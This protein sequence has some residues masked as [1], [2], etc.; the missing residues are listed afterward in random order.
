MPDKDYYTPTDER[1]ENVFAEYRK[2]ITALFVLAGKDQA[3]A[4]EIA[5]QVIEIE[6]NLAANSMGRVQRR[7]PELTYNKL[8]I[9]ELQNLCPAINWTSFLDAAE[10]KGVEDFAVESACFYEIF[11]L[12]FHRFPFRKLEK[13][14]E[15]A[16]NK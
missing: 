2:H 8:S 6:S 15:M 1:G 4:E 7:D 3:A 11:K 13:L 12:F 5:S 10:L 16:P 14:H 9:E